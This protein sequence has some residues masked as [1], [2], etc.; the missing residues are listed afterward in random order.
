[1]TTLTI[2]PTAKARTPSAISSSPADVLRDMRRPTVVDGPAAVNQCNGNL[3]SC[4]FLPPRRTRIVCAMA[5]GRALRPRKGARMKPP[6]ED[7]KP[8]FDLDPELGA[9]APPGV[10]RRTFLM[11]SAVVGSAAVI[12][13]RV[14]TAEEQ[15]KAATAAP[16]K[17]ALAPDLEVVKKS[18]G[19]V[20]TTIDEF[21]KVGPGPSSSHTIGPMRITYDFYQRCTKL[22][23]DQ[24]AKA[25]GI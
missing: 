20:M 5:A 16:P 18:K 11:R 22:P 9:S 25:T 3:P 21:Y 15:A 23:A 14:V 19:P 13:G 10:D 2:A 8:P 17:V 4:Y 12:S 7:E 6:K 1:R 24:L